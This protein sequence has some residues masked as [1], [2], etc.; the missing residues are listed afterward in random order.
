MRTVTFQEILKSEEF[1][2]VGMNQDVI[3][4]I[5]T[6]G[7]EGWNQNGTVGMVNARDT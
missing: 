1:G 7:N 5:Q 2:I 4:M 3:G 6:R